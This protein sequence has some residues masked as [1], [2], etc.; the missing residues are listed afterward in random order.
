MNFAKYQASILTLL[1]EKVPLAQHV[2]YI[3]FALKGDKTDKHHVVHAPIP[4]AEGTV[5]VVVT[6]PLRSTKVFVALTERKIKDVARLLANLE[7]YEQENNLTLRLGE[8]VIVP[9]ML[10]QPEALPFAVLVMPIETSVDCAALPAQAEVGGKFTTFQLIIP[11]SKTEW[12]IRKQN[13]YRALIDYFDATSKAIV[14]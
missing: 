5:H 13:G 6:L 4:S 9:D 11:L 1:F 14:F 12:T 2:Q 8:A 7:E 10:V 3:D